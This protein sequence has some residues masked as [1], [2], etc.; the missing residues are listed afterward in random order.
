MLRSRLL[1]PLV[2]LLGLSIASIASAEFVTIKHN[3]DGCTSG[4]CVNGLALTAART[5]GWIPVHG[6]RAVTFGAALTDA[7]DSVTAVTMDCETSNVSSTTA[8]SGYDICVSTTTSAAGTSTIVC[9]HLWSVANASADHFNL[10]VDNLNADYLQC[11]FAGTGVP[12]AADT[13]I[14]RMLKKTP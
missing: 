10:T 2:A 9:P 12:A 5:T 4:V 3:A 11:S 8:G 7:N 6:Y 14:V 1:L 13:L